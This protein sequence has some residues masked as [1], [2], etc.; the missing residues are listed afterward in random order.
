SRRRSLSRNCAWKPGVSESAGREAPSAVEID[1]DGVVSG[2]SAKIGVESVVA[3]FDT[4]LIEE[5]LEYV[6][7]PLNG[8]IA[9]SPP[10]APPLTHTPNCVMDGCTAPTLSEAA[11][12]ALQFPKGA[13]AVACTTCDTEVP[14]T[15]IVSATSPAVEPNVS[16]VC[17]CPVASVV[18]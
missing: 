17:A 2:E 7:E 12:P 15:E 11:V 5:M 1:I 4:R 16:V 14:L 8:M 3:P 9:N 6:V 10:D 18:A 13:I